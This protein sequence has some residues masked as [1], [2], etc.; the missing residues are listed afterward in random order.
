MFDKEVRAAARGVL[1]D[2][3]RLRIL[4]GGGLDDILALRQFFAVV[5]PLARRAIKRLDRLAQ[6]IPDATLREK[7]LTSLHAKAYHIAGA[8]ILSTFLPSGAREHYVEVVAPLEAL[9]DFLDTLCDREP[10]PS[11]RASRQLHR[12]LAHALDPDAEPVEYFAFGPPGDDGDYLRI[13][14]RRVQRA[15]R[16]LA[17]YEEL[18][19]V[20]APAA[21]LYADTQTYKHLPAQRRELALKEWFAASGRRN[22]RWFEYAAAAGSQFHVYGALYAAFCSRLDL[23]EQTYDAYFPEIAAV[24][25]LLDSFIDQGEDRANRELSFVECY[26]SSEHLERRMQEFCAAG[27]AKFAKLPLPAAHRFA[28]RMMLL[29]YLTHPKVSAQRLDRQADRLL[30]ESAAGMT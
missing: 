5:V 26:A 14:V 12:A 30:R 8:C 15:L 28:L 11:E 18:V 4:A 20:I 1:L 21:Q 6:R 7:A 9:Y 17:G 23:L 13:L 27:S 2:P 16:R 29:F 22:L 3:L 25:V 10:H 19:P 24:H